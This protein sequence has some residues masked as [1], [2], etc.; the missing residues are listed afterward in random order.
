MCEELVTADVVAR[1]REIATL[2]A[3][4]MP[5]IVAAPS[6]MLAES[7]NVLARAY[8]KFLAKELSW[9]AD[10]KIY[11]LKTINRDF[12]TDGWF[13]FAVQPGFYGLVQKGRNYVVADDV[14]TM[15]ATLANL[16][17]FIEENGG[18]VL[19]T[20]VLANGYG[21]H[22]EIALADATLSRLTG[23]LGGQLAGVCKTEVGYELECLTEAEGQFLLRCP[24]YVELREGIDGARDS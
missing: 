19:G 23:H 4:Q 15:G 8:A 13:R 5:P 6:L 1:L 12:S 7:Q 21:N 9:H 17:G 3:G 24:T 18:H 14:C 16:R 11:Q 10:S 20:T 2:S 22:V